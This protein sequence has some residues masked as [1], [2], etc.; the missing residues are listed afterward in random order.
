M[1]RIIAVI[2][3]CLS[4]GTTNAQNISDQ[5][6]GNW[7]FVDVTLISPKKGYIPTMKEQEINLLKL[8]MANYWFKKDYTIVLDAKYMERTGI[9]EA[10]WE[11]DPESKTIMITYVFSEDSELNKGNSSNKSPLPWTID[12]ITDEKLVLNLMDMY[13]VSFEKKKQKETLNAKEKA[14]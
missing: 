3:L 4:L 8:S 10:T 7:R 14:K 2:V 1:K 6:L 9:T 5:L 11:L 12:E 13:V